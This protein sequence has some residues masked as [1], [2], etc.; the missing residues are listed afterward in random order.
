MNDSLA[1]ITE[2]QT[3]RPCGCVGIFLQLFDRNHRF[4]MKLFPK[5]LLS[6]IDD[7]NSGGF[8]YAKHNEMTDTRCESKHK[9]KA[10]SFIARLMVWN[11]CQQDQVVSPKRHKLLKLGAMW[12]TN[13]VLDLADLI[14]KI[15]ILR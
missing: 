3:Q 15:W 4:S 11:R 14:K 5:K 7:E 1:A 8:P 13:L 9:M 2:R 12:Q 10:P 6:Q